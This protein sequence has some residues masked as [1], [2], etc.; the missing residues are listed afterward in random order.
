MESAFLVIL[1][2]D[3]FLLLFEPGLCDKRPLLDRLGIDV[4]DSLV[5]NF[6]LLLIKILIVAF[7]IV[8]AVLHVLGHWYWS[9]VQINMKLFLERCSATGVFVKAILLFQFQFCLSKFVLFW[10]KFPR[11]DNEIGLHNVKINHCLAKTNSCFE[12]FSFCFFPLPPLSLLLCVF[13]DSYLPPT[14]PVFFFHDVSFSSLEC[15]YKAIAYKNL[16][17]LSGCS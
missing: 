4:R 16:S 12:V 9:L 15:L 13:L 5:L 11:W 1:V 7:S 2:I 10:S 14:H 8:N 3:D 17:S 6:V